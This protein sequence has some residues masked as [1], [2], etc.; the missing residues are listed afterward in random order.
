MSRTIAIG[1][2]HGCIAALETVLRANDPQPE[3]LLITLGDYVDRG[4]DS[5]GVVS[6][7]IKL[8]S[9]CRLVPILGNHEEV[10]LRAVAA[11]S[12]QPM[13][14]WMVCGGD[15]TLESYG[16]SLE[17]IP[18]EH[19]DFLRNCRSY[20]ET[21]SHLFLH[22][23]YHPHLPLNQQTAAQL[24]WTSLVQQ[25]PAPHCSG[26]TAIVGHTSQKD[27]QVLD[28]GHLQCI[29]TYCYGGGWLTAFD[30]Q[31]KQYWQADRDGN[32]RT[33]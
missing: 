17:N 4:P 16:T 23:N 32:L 10:M 22:A 3:D 2:I 9:Q 7:L 25:R 12:G 31:A 19:L 18:A 15:A 5:A 30:V 20:V 24:R 21:E 29:D 1:D 13:T 11:G 27:G 33:Q 6:R 14:F 8:E 26:K 28:L